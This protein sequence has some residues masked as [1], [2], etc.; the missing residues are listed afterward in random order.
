MPKDKVQQRHPMRAQRSECR[1]VFDDCAH[2]EIRRLLAEL[3][4]EPVQ[5]PPLVQR[6]FLRQEV[7]VMPAHPE[8]ELLGKAPLVDVLCHCLHL[9]V[10]PARPR[11]GYRQK[12]RYVRDNICI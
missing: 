3:G 7:F 9:F 1:M 2:Q 12:I 4:R 6:G 8:G 11:V 10:P 5:D